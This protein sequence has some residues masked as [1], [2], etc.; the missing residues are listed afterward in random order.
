MRGKHVGKLSPKPQIKRFYLKRRPSRF[1]RPAQSPP[2]S[3]IE[4]AFKTLAF[5][6]HY[7]SQKSF[8]VRL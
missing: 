7:L 4:H 2:Q 3:L 8:D 6:M 1:F 5:S